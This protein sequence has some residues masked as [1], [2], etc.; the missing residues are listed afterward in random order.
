MQCKKNH[1]GNLPK[2]IPL[3]ILGAHALAKIA[4]LTGKYR[5]SKREVKEFLFDF[6]G[7]KVCIGTISNAEHRVSCSLKKSVDE[8]GHAISIQNH[9]HVDEVII[10]RVV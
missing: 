9:L 1:R 8:I 2:G 5:L 6:F 3:G 10:I 7:L 4:A